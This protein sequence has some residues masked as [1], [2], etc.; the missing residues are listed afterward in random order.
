MT[1]GSTTTFSG[2]ITASLQ[3]VGSYEGE[4]GHSLQLNEM[5]NHTHDPLS[6]SGYWMNSTGQAQ[7]LTNT[8]SALS[9][10]TTGNI[11]G[12]GAQK[13]LNVTQPGV[14]YNILIKL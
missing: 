10:G 12:Y 13:A 6:G 7:G 1:G 5:V 4:Y 9:A 11:T 3:P 14:F 8:A 2:T